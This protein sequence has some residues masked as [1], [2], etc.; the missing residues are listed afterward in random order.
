MVPWYRAPG[1]FWAVDVADIPPLGVMSRH[2]PG[3]LFNGRRYRDHISYRVCAR[4]ES[5]PTASALQVGFTAAEVRILS[6]GY[7]IPSV[8]DEVT[9]HRQ[10]SGRVG[11][12]SPISITQPGDI[13]GRVHRA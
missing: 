1:R 12:D 5:V 9:E 4:R 6:T 13:P 8:P 3:A 10:V 7:R 2:V 11:V